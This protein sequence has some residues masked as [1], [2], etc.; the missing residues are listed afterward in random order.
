MSRV[1]PPATPFEGVTPFAAKT[2]G[3]GHVVAVGGISA[4][5]PKGWFGKCVVNDVPVVESVQSPGCG[6]EVRLTSCCIRQENATPFAFICFTGV[7]GR[8]L[9]PSQPP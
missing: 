8:P 5:I 4:S 6:A 3:G 7:A 9:T 1:Q 2:P